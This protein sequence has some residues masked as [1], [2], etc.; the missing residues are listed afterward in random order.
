VGGELDGAE[1]A[2][3][4]IGSSTLN[5]QAEGV[6]AHIRAPYCH[7]PH[8]C[9]ICHLHSPHPATAF[10]ICHSCSLTME[11]YFVCT[12]GY[13]KISHSMVSNIDSILSPIIK[14]FWIICLSKHQPHL[15]STCKL[16][17]YMLQCFNIPGGLP[18]VYDA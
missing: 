4:S 3:I 2:S 1:C 17:N 12:P 11:T 9:T 5:C 14:V 15:S 16:A 18:H 13:F 6:H 7:L 8:Q 10:N